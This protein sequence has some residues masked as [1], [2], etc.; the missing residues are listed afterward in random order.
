MTWFEAIPPLVIITAAIGAMGSLQAVVHR[1]CHQGKNKKV[2]RD[3]FSYLMD[4]RDERLKEEE[5]AAKKEA[6]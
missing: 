3:H 6:Q 5:A 2:Q 1:A 4:K